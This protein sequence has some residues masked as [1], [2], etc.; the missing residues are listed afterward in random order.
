MTTKIVN[1]F[2]YVRIPLPKRK[3]VPR[4]IYFV[5]IIKRKMYLCTNTLTKFILYAFANL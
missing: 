5:I 2:Y 4:R 3:F 1:N